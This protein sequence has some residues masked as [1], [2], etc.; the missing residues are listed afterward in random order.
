MK[1]HNSNNDNASN[2]ENLSPIE[3]NKQLSKLPATTLSTEQLPSVPLDGFA[4]KVRKEAF[5][6]RI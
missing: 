6:G 4:D 5:N 1:K 2:E 3:K